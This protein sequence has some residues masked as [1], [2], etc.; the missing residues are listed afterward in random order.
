MSWFSDLF[1]KKS[2]P[3]LPQYEGPRSQIGLT[4]GQELYDQ[5]LARKGASGRLQD[6]YY[7]NIYQPTA[8]QARA[9]WSNY[10][11]PEISSSASARGMGRSSLVEDLIRRSA[12][13]REGGLATLAGNLKSQG[14]EQGLA[15]ENFGTS[16]LQDF[17][18][19][20]ANLASKAAGMD[21]SRNMNQYG[22]NSAASEANSN[23]LT[24]ALMN[25]LVTA[26]NVYSTMSGINTNNALT[27]Y[28]LNRS[29]N[30]RAIVSDPVSSSGKYPGGYAG[31]SG[32]IS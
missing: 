32:L 20:E 16:G 9:D 26:G 10:T 2:V 15:Q 27:D 24:N 23:R 8:N 12:Q 25:G 31:L 4:G 22:L 29:S 19:N 28:L 21:F 11:L 7:N 5:L 1:K 18:G 14:F 17:V 30:R 6:V 13:E 3:E